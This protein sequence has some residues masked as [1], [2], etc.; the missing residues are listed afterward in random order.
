MNKIDLIIENIEYAKLL[1]EGAHQDE[2]LDEALAAARELKAFTWRKAFI[3]GRCEGVDADVCPSECHCEVGVEPIFKRG[4][5]CYP[6][7]EVT[8]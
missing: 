7:D 8:K 1:K 2:V 3:C 5:I 6:T 4:F